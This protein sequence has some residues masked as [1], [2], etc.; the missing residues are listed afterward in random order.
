MRVRWEGTGNEWTLSGPVLGRGA[1]ATIY[2]VSGRPALAAKVYHTPT[3]EHAAKLA[4]MLA[5]PPPARWAEDHPIV[6]WPVGRLL[7]AGDV[8]GYVM[9]RMIEGR[10]LGDYCNPGARR[11]ACPLFHYGYLL[12]TARNL[13]AA[14]QVLH[15]GGYVVGDINESNVLVSTQAL[16]TLV[17]VDAFQVPGPGRTYRCRGCRQEYAAPE[18]QATIAGATDLGPEHDAFGLAVLIFQIL[19]QGVHPFAGVGGS[20]GEAPLAA[21]IV[22]GHWPYSWDRAV[23]VRPVQ[24]APPWEVLPPE[25]QELFWRCFDAGHATPSARPTAAEWREALDEADGRLA[26]CPTN[27]QHVHP[28]GLDTCP[29][30]IWADVQGRDAFPSAEEV[31]ARRETAL[32]RPLPS[33]ALPADAPQMAGAAGGGLGQLGAAVEPRSWLVWLAVV[34]LGSMSGLLWAL[35]NAPEQTRTT[36]PEQQEPEPLPAGADLAEAARQELAEYQRADEQ[37]RQVLQAYNRTLED[38]KRGLKNKDDVTEASRVLQREWDRF[39]EIRRHLQEKVYG[40]EPPPKDAPTR[41]PSPV[42]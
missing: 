37:Y 8:V 15:D 32:A 13:A 3:P 34:A 35:K 40:P 16:V 25:I 14:V 9:P 33:S 41:P 1:S 29:W 23:P 28:R 5:A 24:Q 10:P 22:A 12:R 4:A 19:M 21:R 42:R 30:C 26:I 38:Q 36:T 27:S 20:E 2:P 18:A 31:K 11:H 39:Q 6:A 17:G 7:A